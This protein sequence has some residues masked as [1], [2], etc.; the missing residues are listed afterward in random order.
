MLDFFY[1]LIVIQSHSACSNIVE[2]PQVVCMKPPVL[3]PKEKKSGV[4]N[5]NQNLSQE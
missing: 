5:P 4:D 2:K 1:Y 3:L